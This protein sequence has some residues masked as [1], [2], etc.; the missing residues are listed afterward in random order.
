[1]PPPV[2]SVPET[3]VPLVAAD[4]RQGATTKAAL[5]HLFREGATGDQVDAVVTTKGVK[6]KRA[7]HECRIQLRIIEG[8]KQRLSLE[9]IET[10]WSKVRLEKKKQPKKRA[11][12]KAR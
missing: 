10:D 3:T 1:M 5:K 12:K 11:M 2:K 9:L 8:S 7:Q 4:L 6:Q